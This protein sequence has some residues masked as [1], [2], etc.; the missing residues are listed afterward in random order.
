MPSLD[1]NLNSKILKVSIIIIYTLFISLSVFGQRKI[2]LETIKYA[3]V[4]AD[5]INRL[6]N[7]N[8]S[9]P[10]FLYN[11]CLDYQKAF[12]LDMHHPLPIRKLIVDKITNQRAIE[13]ILSRQV[14]A[15]DKPCKACGEIKK[16]PIGLT[17][18]TIPLLKESFTDLLIN[19]LYELRYH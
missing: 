11:P 10:N 6:K 19:R 9:L 3:K 16:E 14:S 4:C 8:D 12:W 5:S 1:R 7:E 15:L 18:F 13:I 2:P 17:Y